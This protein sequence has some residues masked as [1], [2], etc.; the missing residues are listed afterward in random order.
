VVLR[1]EKVELKEKN[2]QLAEEYAILKVKV[3]NMEASII[4]VVDEQF[5]ERLRSISAN[6]YCFE[7]GAL[8]YLVGNRDSTRDK[9]SKRFGTRTVSSKELKK[10]VSDLIWEGVKDRTFFDS[11]K[12]WKVKPYWDRWGDAIGKFF[13]VRDNIDY[14]H[15]ENN[16]SDA[17]R[18]YKGPLK[19]FINAYKSSGIK[20]KGYDKKMKM[21]CN[22]VAFD[23]WFEKYLDKE[24]RLR[25]YSHL[26]S[27]RKPVF[28]AMDYFVAGFSIVLG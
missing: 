27:Y 1:A 11:A 16:S 13:G 22:D 9:I 20:E 14:W 2:D 7:L 12:E 21:G 5:S 19:R 23:Y 28:A 25:D 15:L 3:D 26:D 17:G 4:P 10:F 18:F 6:P 8:T 24:V